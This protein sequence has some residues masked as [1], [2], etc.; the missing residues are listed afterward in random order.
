MVAMP[1]GQ[2]TPAPH[3]SVPYTEFAQVARERDQWYNRYNQE[4]QA[5][6]HTKQL[7]ADERN[8]KAWERKLWKNRQL[9]PAHKL[10]L[11]AMKE[12]I[13]RAQTHDEEGRARINLTTISEAIGMSPDTASR[14]LKKFAQQ[15]PGLIDV[16]ERAEM[17]EN[18]E[19]WTRKYA[20][21]NS[22]MLQAPDQLTPLVPRAHGGDHRICQ[23]CGSEHVKIKRKTTLIC[24]NEKCRGYNCEVLI[25]ETDQILNASSSQDDQDQAKNFDAQGGN[26]Q[27]TI[28]PVTPPY[29]VGCDDNGPSDPG[30]DPQI[31]E[32]DPDDLRAAAA[33]LLALAGQH[34]AHIEM[35]RRGESK[36]YTVDRP[37]KIGD[38][39]NHLTGGKARG[40][41]CS[42]PDGQTRG[43]CWDADDAERWEVLRQAA[44]QLAQAG[45]F[46]ILEESPAGRGGHLWV[47][48]DAL[49]NT[50]AARQH[51]YSIAPELADLVEYWPGPQDAKR[52]NRVRLPGAKYVRP[53]ISAWC[54]LTAV[55]TGESSH[56]GRSAATLLLANQTPAAIV[57]AIQSQDDDQA[58]ARELATQSERP[59][60]TVIAG[61]AGDLP[62]SQDDQAEPES[63]MQAG[64]VDGQWYA[65]YNTPEGKR[66]WFSWTP[67][68]LAAWWNDRHS[69]EEIRPRERNGMALSP[70]VDE[71]TAS[72]A[73]RQTPDGE[74]Y[75]DFSAGA[76]RADG[77]HDTGDALELQARISGAPKPELMRQAARELLQEARQALESAARTGQPIPAWLEEIITD[78]GR[79]H[80]ARVA[81]QAGYLVTNCNEI[82][83]K[84]NENVV[85]NCDQAQASTTQDQAEQPQPPA[86]QTAQDY[87]Q[88]GLTGF[89]VPVQAG[90]PASNLLQS[91]QQRQLRESGV[92]VPNSSQLE[93]QELEAIKS[94]GEAHKWPAL[95]IDSQEIIA[96]GRPAWLHFVWLSHDRKAQRQ[97]YQ[98]ITQG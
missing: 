63:K 88:G 41:N 91:D 73:Y 37:L 6:T 52:W 38:L 32:G 60:L 97:V 66:L 44:R 14:T 20:S 92:A 34:D 62:N 3:E 64:Q 12:A 82:G 39:L 16:T 75:T 49:V 72:T 93:M 13:E 31:D 10:G 35:S 98:H 17:Q 61:G 59:A 95:V 58:Q 1:Q 69:L 15:L 22:E 80:Y 11:I 19:R 71:R 87:H 7:L 45:Y 8:R 84:R 2:Q 57:P 4:H 51:V 83:E 9:N 53:G 18:G 43:L 26:L 28:K 76:R 50:S 65:K 47:I 94:Y 29:G 77:T 27:D 5:H 74:R 90:T 89:S 56:N 81:S 25:S 70:N 79:E 30:D 33:L 68:Q 21:L 40:A 96:A 23:K 78:A 48:Y 42:Y 46:V 85:T 36:Y 55:A 54:K 24:L 86:I 67:A